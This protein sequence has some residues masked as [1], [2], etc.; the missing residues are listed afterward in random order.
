MITV[1][2]RGEPEGR[3]QPAPRVV[4]RGRNGPVVYK[5]GRPL[6]VL[7]PDNGTEAYQ[8]ALAM[9]AKVVMGSRPL[10]LG[11]VAVA[12]TAVF[13]VPASWSNKKRDAAL[14]GVVRP[15]GKPDVD[16]LYKQIDAFKGVVWQDDAI[17]VD[18]RVVKVYGEEPMLRVEVREFEEGGGLIAGM[19]GMTLEAAGESL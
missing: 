9:Q 14:A 17:V 3:K 13:P 11:A 5:N 12:V 18:C 6:V 15:T 4:T 2:L 16:N 19:S 10:L 8:K 1:V 7:H